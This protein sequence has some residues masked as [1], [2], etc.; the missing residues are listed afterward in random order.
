[1]FYSLFISLYLFYWC[2]WYIVSYVVVLF[3]CRVRWPLLL[4]KAPMNKIY[5]YYY[6][7]YKVQAKKTNQISIFQYASACHSSG[8]LVSSVSFDVIPDWLQWCCDQGLS[9]GSRLSAAGLPVLLYSYFQTCTNFW[10]ISWQSVQGA[11]RENENVQVR[12]SWV[13]PASAL[14][15]IW[16][17]SC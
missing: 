5:Y 8:G 1:M 12:G 6:C 10:V 14:E 7:Y 9:V 3:I 11:I 16:M 2:F 13:S 15:N 17:S 4:W